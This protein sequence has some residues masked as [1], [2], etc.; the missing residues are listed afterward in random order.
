MSNFIINIVI[1]KI[2][3]GIENHARMNALGENDLYVKIQPVDEEMNPGFVL[4]NHTKPI[5]EI[6]FG[7]FVGIKKVLGF[8]VA[9]E[10]QEWIK[11]FLIM[12]ASENGIDFYDNH[13]YFIRITP[14][15]DLQAYMYKE[16]KPFKEIKIEY[17]L[18]TS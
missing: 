16:D 3:S 14:R 18:K 17:I 6:S 5:Q 13:Y 1:D 15:G 10:G 12:S 2:K 11:K 8:N 7:D 4:C 9:D